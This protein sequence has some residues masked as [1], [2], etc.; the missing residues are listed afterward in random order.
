ML[1]KTKGIVLRYT[2]Y[3][4]TSIIV[5]I[6]TEL[7]GLQ[8]YIINGIRS[9]SSKNKI[10][11]F[12]PLTLLDLV[13][14]YKENASIKRIKE[15]KC[16]YPYQSLQTDIRKSAIAM[17]INEVLN[18]AVKEEN[19]AQELFDFILHALVYL[20]EQSSHYENFHLVMLIKL[21]RLL[22]FGAWNVQEVLGGSA[23]NQ[24]EENVMDK[25]L[26]AN[27]SDIISMSQETRRSLLDLILRF[28]SAHVD[29]F[30][31][32]KSVQ[33]LKEVMS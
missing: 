11:L 15:V 10:A 29:A 16:L 24:Q 27:Y 2:R 21:S 33:V 14:Y 12:Q 5:T 13:V 19:H 3:G 4:D 28:Y 31:E 30:G 32:I 8:S 20:D 7:F 25:L 6:F 18:K 22:G 26:Q 23:S 17:F 9:K 1:H